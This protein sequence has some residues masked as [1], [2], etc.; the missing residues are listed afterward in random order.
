MVFRAAGAAS[1]A[2]A[3]LAILAAVTLADPVGAGAGS[4]G[5]LDPTSTVMAVGPS[6]PVLVAG[7]F[8][9]GAG[10][11][12]LGA[13]PPTTPLT[14][15]VGL[16][17]QNPNG[18]LSYEDAL[19]I[20]GTGAYHHFLSPSE[21][22][23]RY[24]AS[25]DTIASVRGYFQDQ[26]LRAALSPDGLLLT[27]TGPAHLVAGAFETSFEDYR[28]ADG[29]LF[30]SHT[31][32]ARL[33]AGVPVSGVYGLGNTTTPRPLDLTR[34]FA[35]AP[36]T[37]GTTCAS[38]SGLNPCDIW[39]AY[40]SAGLLQ[41]GTNGTGERIGVVDAYDS[42]EPQTQL[43]SDLA[44][45][46]SL[47]D[48]PSPPVTFNYP[49]PS[50]LNLNETGSS[51]WG[52]EEAL[53][54][55]WTHASAPGASIAMT[56]APN[57]GVGLYLA[58]DWLVSHQRV[59]EIS[60]SW[61]EPDVG[62]FNAFSGACSSECNAS[63]DG[64][65]E[66][67][68]PVLEAAALEGIS[69][70]VATG[71]CGSSDGTS[72]VSTDYPSSDPS[73]TGVGGTYLTVNSTGAYESEIG[74][75]GNS[76]GAR[77]PG[78]EN[79]GGSGGGYSPFPRPY[80]QSG[81]GLPVSPATRGVPDVSADASDPVEFVAGGGVGLVGGTS[82][83]TP[84]WAG[85]G[86]ISDQFAGH[87]LGLL[88]PSF[89]SILNGPDYATDFHDITSGNNGYDAAI[90]WDPVTGVGTPIVGA[91]V[92]DLSRPSV[93]VSSLHALLYAN[94]TSGEAPLEV[95]FAIATSGGQS[96]YPLQG[97]YFGDGTS[98]LAS[99]GVVRHTFGEAGVYAAEAFVADSSGNLTVSDPVAIVVGGGGSL[100]VTLTPSNP[101]P[102]VGAPVTFTTAVHGG[103]AP[104]SYLYSFGDGT[105][106]NLSSA[107][108]TTHAYAV[109]GAF[110]ATVIVQDSGHPIAGGRGGPLPIDVEGAPSRTCSNATGPFTVSAVTSPPVRDAPA[111][112]PSLFQTQGGVTNEGGS[113]VTDVF[114]STDPYVGACGCTIFRSPGTFPL[115]LNATD[116][117]GDRASNETNVTVAP[118]LTASFGATPTYG[119][120]PLTVQFSV[121]TGGGYLADANDT[122]W[123]FGD[124]S[125]AVGARVAHTYTSAGFY[126]ATGD[127]WDQGHG[128]ASEG[129]VIEVLPSGGGSVP[130]LWATFSPAVNLSSGTTV[131]FIAHA[132]LP[133]G[134]TP[135]SPL[136][137]KLGGNA[138][139]WGSA[140][141][142]TYTAGSADLSSN[143]YASITADWGDGF[144]T[145]VAT[146][147]TP[148]L[149][150]SESGS[151]VPAVDALALSAS[152]GPTEGAP[153]V[154][155]SGTAAVTAPGGG[156]AN[157]SFGDGMSESGFSVDHTYGTAGAYTALVNGSDS[158]G[159]VAFAS[160]G[161]DIGAGLSPV[162]AVSGGPSVQ[163]GVA[164][165]EVSFVAN[166]SGGTVPYTYE[167]QT[168][169][170][171]LNANQTFEHRY[172]TPGRYSAALTVRDG[173][174]AMVELSWSIVI[175][176]PP[177]TPTSAPASELPVYLLI[178][179]VVVVLAGLSIALW[180]RRRDRPPTP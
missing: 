147:V 58:V 164:P 7:G 72:G 138:T 96:P 160:F 80:W 77:S 59:D 56:F 34:G 139:A 66:I 3:V 25:P 4:H 117:I 15:L 151:F 119:P 157:W 137:W 16:P 154:V 81:E 83:A 103:T 136:F 65:Y 18:F 22:A 116:L 2:V 50:S 106:L 27:V 43:A 31:S 177:S 133:N 176:S 45:F 127:A 49:V 67:L 63:S 141:E 5:P 24:G 100:N 11:Q 112:F 23:D 122:F 142:Q 115:S 165:L 128:N 169:D 171:T 173:D 48:L 109:A 8:L 38:T 101:A 69:V 150:A 146:L 82:L 20:P 79:Q 120:A 111:D 175:E 172:L 33:P 86:A 108:V 178:G 174:G 73:V 131:H 130:T 105:F 78:C 6:G 19:S 123:N 144:P 102:L 166:A 60:L 17:S 91:L 74:W 29:H 180:D 54:I 41:N 148:Q 124:G 30:F 114:A 35:P 62:V 9:P 162:L 92:Q 143:L 57:S 64:S 93:P 121:S 156:V 95:R 70:F 134:S 14:V 168:G 94:A 32:A 98:A 140:A 1:I 132:A 53:D 159:D 10:V 52:T 44:T 39:N 152:G 55:E 40:D 153:G 129:F 158:W 36:V 88:D 167:W 28:G 135:V 85:F 51:G 99:N 13:L 71:D 12:A 118:A 155:W 75:S 161:V 149:F 68:G 84:I 104:Y 21:V 125:G 89:Y 26:G 113:G 163:G 126:S 97:V 37:P 46:D 179:G 42:G 47:F 76:S 87:D 61:G 170:G 107:H 90:G 145:T 110:C